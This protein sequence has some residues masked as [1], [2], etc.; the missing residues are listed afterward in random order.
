ML[1][2]ANE[3]GK[4]SSADLASLETDDNFTSWLE[5]NHK[6]MR[7]LTSASYSEQYNIISQFYSD[8]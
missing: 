5:Q 8:L 1:A 6:T 3:N 2:T 4:F 7:D